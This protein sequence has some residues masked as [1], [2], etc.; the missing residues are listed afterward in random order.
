MIKPGYIRLFYK[1]PHYYNL[2]PSG[3]WSIGKWREAGIV[4]GTDDA[5]SEEN[6]RK[7]LRAMSGADFFLPID[8]KL[9]DKFYDGLGLFAEK[10]RWLYNEIKAIEEKKDGWNNQSF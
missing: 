9:L 8:G 5:D 4:F 2:R 7:L 10:S 3:E 1:A 6:F